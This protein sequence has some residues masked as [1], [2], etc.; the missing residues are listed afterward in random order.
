MTLAWPCG[1]PVLA[2][3]VLQQA[4]AATGMQ[5][6][7]GYPGG[8]FAAVAA[9]SGNSPF[10]VMPPRPPGI[11][12]PPFGPPPPQMPASEGQ[13]L[14]CRPTPTSPLLE[15]SEEVDVGSST[16]YSSPKTVGQSSPSS[17]KAA[18]KAP[19]ADDSVAEGDS[20]DGESE[21]LSEG[22]EDGP[23][24]LSQQQPK[25]KSVKKPKSVPSSS[26]FQPYLDIEKK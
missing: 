24:S 21:R 22:G 26:L 5:L 18:K 16:S 17:P 10:G 14:P 8:L 13:V 3:Y 19:G 1:D 12:H 4:A 20:D 7:G 9:A 2:A 11:P 15:T 23:A 6:P 25:G